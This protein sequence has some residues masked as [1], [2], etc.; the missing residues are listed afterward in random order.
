M[1]KELSLLPVNIQLFAEGDSGEQKDPTVEELL[2]QLQ[3]LQLNTVPKEEYEK[4]L[5]SNKKL[6]EQITKHRPA[7]DGK[8]KKEPTHADIVDRI[9]ERTANLLDGTSYD[10]IKSLIENYQDMKT[11]GLDVSN[12]DE[13]VVFQLEEI[14]KEAKGDP[15]LFNA[16]MEQRVKP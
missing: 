12:V 14:V 10:A 15:I 3:E 8:D 6:V 5:E 4:Q 9:K 16:L 1:P 7:P 11:L 2:K 13:N